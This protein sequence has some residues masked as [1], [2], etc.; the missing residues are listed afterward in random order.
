MINVQESPFTVSSLELNSKNIDNEFGSNFFKLKF[1]KKNIKL[2]SPGSAEDRN[3]WMRIFLLII[4]MNR[5][6]IDFD[7][8]NPFIFEKFQ[9]KQ[10]AHITKQESLSSPDI[11][12]QREIKMKVD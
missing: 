9:K 2:L 1:D 5:L 4:Q 7:N 10:V 11:T 6:K 12:P 3:Q 8:I